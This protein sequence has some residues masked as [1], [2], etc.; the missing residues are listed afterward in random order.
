MRTPPRAFLRRTLAATLSV[1]LATG[2]ALAQT[3][4][5][6]AAPAAQKA[7]LADTLQG[8][9]KAEYEAG[10][11]LYGDGDFAAALV[12]FQRAYELSK[13]VRL[14]WNMAAC[15]KN[16]RHYARVLSLVQQYL[17]EGASMLSEQD[18]RDATDLA[19][20]I[21][22]FVSTLRVDVDE[23]GAAVFIDDEQTGTSPLAEP[24]LVDIG[25]R[26]IKV[27]KPGFKDFT[28]TVQ[29]EGATEEKISVHL[30]KDVHQGRVVISAS[31][32]DTIIIDGKPVGEGHYEGVVPSGGHTLR[33]TAPGMR[34]YQA[35]INV[36]DNETRNIQITLEGEKSGVP[37]WVWIAAGGVLVTG[38]AVGGYFAFKP[39]DETLPAVP[40]TINPGVVTLPLVRGR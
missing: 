2:P 1:A 37:T 23:P 29:A 18:K 9:A 16:L 33:V 31:P 21:K 27:T 15:E 3:G 25:Q 30:E 26:R 32:K 14:L 28:K 40:G 11:L 22:A 35:E 39:K 34:A 20:A 10:R 36:Q 19:N 24:L 12:K 5:A 8:P 17:A 38:A 7:S 4:A 6:P 13:D